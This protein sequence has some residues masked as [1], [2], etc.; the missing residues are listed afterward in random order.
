MQNENQKLW[1]VSELFYPEESSTAFILTEIAEKLSE[2]YQVQAL[3]GTSVYE[4]D[5]SRQHQNLKN[6]KITRKTCVI[7]KSGSKTKRNNLSSKK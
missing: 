3:A 7:Y 2:K 5:D 4:I 6:I 1:I